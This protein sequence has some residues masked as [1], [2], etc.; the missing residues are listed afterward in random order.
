MRLRLAALVAAI[1]LSVAP[2][3]PDDAYATAPF[4]PGD[5][6]EVASDN[7][8]TASDFELAIVLLA[9]IFASATAAMVCH[10]RRNR[11]R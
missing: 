3:V 7:T 2:M 4:N 8:P 10:G 9:I 11:R 5:T 1:M 6:E